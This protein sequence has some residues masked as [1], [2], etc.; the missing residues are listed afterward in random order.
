M[1]IIAAIAAGNA[2]AWMIHGATWWLRCHCLWLM[3]ALGGIGM[4]C[5]SF[6]LWFI[7]GL[8]GAASETDAQVAQAQRDTHIFLAI[9]AAIVLFAGVTGFM[10]RREIAG[11]R[12]G[13]SSWCAAAIC[14]MGEMQLALWLGLLGQN[15][16]VRPHGAGIWSSPAWFSG[17]LAITLLLLAL[18][19]PFVVRVGKLLLE[20]V[21]ESFRWSHTPT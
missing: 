4:V 1:T 8:M 7:I 16:L 6:A 5:G 18:L 3:V 21:R 11:R 9:V 17:S 10:H 20:T 2:L 19:R 15:L 14:T 12:A 13:F